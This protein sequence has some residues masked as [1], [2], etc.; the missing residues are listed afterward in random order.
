MKVVN[1]PGHGV[2]D[3]RC[4]GMATRWAGFTRRSPKF[5]TL[6]SWPLS[7]TQHNTH[8]TLHFLLHFG[9]ILYMRLYAE[10][11]F[12]LIPHSYSSST[13]FI[14]TSDIPWNP[15][16]N[17]N[18]TVYIRQKKFIRNTSSQ[19]IIVTPSFV[20]SCHDFRT[21]KNSFGSS[22]T[23]P[24]RPCRISH[25]IRDSSLTVHAYTGRPSFCAFRIN[26]LPH[27]VIRMACAM[28][29]ETFGTVKK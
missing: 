24:S 5:W 27:G 1:V 22:V 9:C 6:P 28:L 20:P 17:W 4:G 13:D 19:V 18:N 14:L 21:S 3:R 16:M 29:K 11:V 26:S 7:S 8:I 10:I 23:T 15:N 2:L 12:I 25:R